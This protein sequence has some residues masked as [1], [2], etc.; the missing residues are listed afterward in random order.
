MLDLILLFFAAFA[1]ATIFPA[2]S[3]LLLINLLNKAQ[4]QDSLL[5]LTA[6][7]GNV[8]GATLNWLIGGYFLYL[9]KNK[10]KILKYKKIFIKYGKTTLLFSWVP[11]IGDALTIIAGYYKVNFMSFLLLVAIGKAARYWFIIY[12]FN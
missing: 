6:T 8:L 5:F 9:S 2:Q 3:E 10:S 7:S 4:Y 1:A 11:L 12:L